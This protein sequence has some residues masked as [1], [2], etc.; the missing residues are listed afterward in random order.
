MKTASNCD[1]TSCDIDS[2][3]IAAAATNAATGRPD[4]IAIIHS[5]ATTK[6]N[7]INSRSHRNDGRVSGRENNSNGRR[8][9]R[10][11]RGGGGATEDTR[12]C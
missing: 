2:A 8:E 5:T 1:L 11:F 12:A 4:F 9:A 7:K 3:R 10:S 6:K